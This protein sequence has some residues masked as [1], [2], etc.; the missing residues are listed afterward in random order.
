LATWR[1][2]ADAV[3]LSHKPKVLNDL[4]NGRSL[5]FVKPVHRVDLEEAGEIA[6]ADLTAVLPTGG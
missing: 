3:D 6:P 4:A 5:P 1:L 2:G